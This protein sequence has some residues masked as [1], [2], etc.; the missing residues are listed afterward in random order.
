M[1][2]K[3]KRTPRAVRN[4]LLLIAGKQPI[5]QK[6][7]DRLLFPFLAHLYEVK[8]G[9]GEASSI[10]TV[11]TTL[12]AAHDAAL[13]YRLDGLMAA[14]EAAGEAAGDAWLESG[15]KCADRSIRDRV[16]LTGDD[17]RKLDTFARVLSGVLPVM[18]LQAWI[19]FM[20]CAQKRWDQFVADSCFAQHAA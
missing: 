7:A 2:T 4:P 15:Q 8:Q 1:S 18:E 6:D 11:T 5:G 16:V 19:Y 3:P 17:M 10:R 14:G 12:A 9:H 13:F 20:D